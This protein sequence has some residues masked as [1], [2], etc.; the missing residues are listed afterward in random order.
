[1]TS[2]PR[3]SALAALLLATFCLMACEEKPPVTAVEGAPR[4]GDPGVIAAAEPLKEPPVPEAPEEALPAGL[5]T[6]FDLVA[7]RHL[8]H[9]EDHGLTID[10]GQGSALKYVQGRWKNPW[11][12]TQQSDQHLYAYPSG[13][14]AVLRLPLGVDASPGDVTGQGWSVQARLKPVG[15]QSCDLFL[16]EQGAPERKIASFELQPDWHT[17]DL[18]L[19]EDVT[20]H[21]E[22]TLRFHFSRSRDV[23]G[24]GKSAAAFDWVRLGP[25]LPEQS[26][27]ARL[28]E[29]FDVTSRSVTL[30]PGQRLS[31][32]TVMGHKERFVAELSSPAELVVRADGDAL[33]SYDLKSGDVS[34]DLSEWADRAVRLELVAGEQQQVTF[35]R[36]ALATHVEPERSGSAPHYIIVWLIDT[37]RADHLKAYNPQSDVQTPHLDAFAEHAALFERATVQGNSSLPS[38]ASIFTAAYPPAHGVIKESSRLSKDATLLGEAMKHNGFVTGLFSSN[39]YVSEKWGFARGFDHEFNPI[40][41]GTPSKAEHLWP[42]AQ[43]WLA[44]QRQEDASKPV[45]LYLNT[46]D[47]HVPYDPPA[48]QLALYYEG[49]EKGRVGRVSPRATGELLHELA[50]SSKSKLSKEEAAY[51]RAL[52][53][54]EISYNDLWFGRMLADLEALGIAEETMIIVT[55]DHGEEFGEYG[56]YGH[57]TSVNQELVDVPLLIGYSPWTAQ[58][59]RVQDSVEV[60]SLYPTLL[61]ARGVERDQ[62]PQ[63]V[64]ASSLLKYLLSPQRRHPEAAVSYH[65]DFLRAVR[66]GD[67]K[68]HLYQGDNDPMF[69]LTYRPTRYED[70][71]K[72]EASDAQDV[73]RANPVA[74][75]AMRDAIAFQVAFD[76]RGWRRSVD[77]APNN[78]TEESAK[79]L[80]GAW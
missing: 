8:A 33:K 24:V 31:W 52:Y 21:G 54:G 6:V 32:Y 40:R 42:K 35:E 41:E 68:Y 63:S 56:R 15:D 29:L 76:D 10:L 11:F 61:E 34:V 20:L 36:P 70:Y 49:G 57:G 47:P 30:K 18:A 77:G 38:S 17:Y 25:N 80:D 43:A 65:N 62:W 13:P 37:L 71:T 67:Y 12:D 50:G 74:R 75:R 28:S 9:L 7:N 46:S 51:L 1:M 69:R 64:Q 16:S 45:F 2:S 48:E 55:S 73:S 72:L 23:P 22:V 5:V 79:R 4:S 27:P 3:S 59:F 39:G 44:A 19:P 60:M 66:L 26:A 14:G 78:H 58:G 53:K